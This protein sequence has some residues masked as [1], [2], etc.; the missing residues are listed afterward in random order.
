MTSNLSQ[1]IR[2]EGTPL[3]WGGSPHKA[4]AKAR[5]A[6]A[7]ANMAFL[8]LRRLSPDLLD[9]ADEDMTVLSVCT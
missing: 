2:S 6:P 8:S 4:A 9:A 3:I 5:I 1:N 7:P